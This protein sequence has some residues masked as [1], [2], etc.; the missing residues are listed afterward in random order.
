[1]KFQKILRFK[2]SKSLNFKKGK[3]SKEIENKNLNICKKTMNPSKKLLT[4]DFIKKLFFFKFFR[5]F[6]SLKQPKNQL[7]GKRKS[8]YFLQ[9][10]KKKFFQ[11]EYNK[12]HLKKKN[13]VFKNSG[14]SASNLEVKC[15]E[16][17]CFIFCNRMS[18]YITNFSFKKIFLLN[19]FRLK[20]K[21]L[22][23]HD[24][25]C[26]NFQKKSSPNHYEL[27][28]FDNLNVFFEGNEL[29]KNG[30]FFLTQNF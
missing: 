14:R 10:T 2:K 25:F 18:I 29:E 4:F 26:K 6:S 8:E 12:T 9:Q 24:T 5:N 23:K 19:F 28:K 17:K 3:N 30:E 1:M 15:Y 16:K 13:R 7:Q 11:F 20:K 27:T 21:F 22:K